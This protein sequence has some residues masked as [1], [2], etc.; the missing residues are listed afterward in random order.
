MRW[1]TLLATVLL[2]SNLAA[3]API[4]KKLRKSPTPNIIGTWRVSDST[5]EVWIFRDDGT[6][7]YGSSYPK[8]DGAA[9]FTFDE[10]VRPHE[11]TWCQDSAKSQYLGIYEYVDDVLTI[12]FSA[13]GEDRAKKITDRSSGRAVSFRK[14]EE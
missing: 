10:T 5:R 4:P 2:F 7:G 9:A 3:A 14:I 1:L 11:I 6:A 13:S 8:F 12:N